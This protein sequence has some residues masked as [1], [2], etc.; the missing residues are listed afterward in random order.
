MKKFDLTTINGKNVVIDISQLLSDEV[1]YINATKLAKQFG[2]DLSNFMR[3]V[4]FLEYL[5][6]F[7]SVKSTELK[8]IKTKQGKYGGTY[9]HSEIVVFFLRWLSAEFAVKCDLFIKHTIQE[10]QNEKLIIKATQEA[11]KANNEWVASRNEAKHTRN[12]LTDAIKEFCKYATTQRG[13]PY[14]SG[15]CPYYVKFTNIPYT[16]LGVHKPKVKCNLRDVYSGA[17][18]E[19]IEYLEEA[20]TNLIRTHII[21]ETEYHKAFKNIMQ[22]MKYEAELIHHAVGHNS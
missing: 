16:I 14:K 8:L 2:K 22:S 7:N 17:V 15:K 9:I 20:L 3:S 6:A 18:V 12:A 1:L 10:I 11:N 5:E 21:Q 19:N 13:T 4:E